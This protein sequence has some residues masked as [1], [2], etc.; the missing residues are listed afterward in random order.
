MGNLILPKSYKSN[1]TLRETQRAIKLLKDTFQV[2]L[3]RALNLDRVTAPV[4]VTKASGINDDLNGIE[5]KVEFDMKNIEGICEVVQSLAKWKRM[6]LYRYGYGAGEGIFTDMNAIRRDDDCDNLHS[7]YVDQWDWEK[8]ICRE[9]RNIDFLKDTVTKIIKALVET[10]DVLNEA[11]PQLTKR[12]NEDVFFI[13]TQELEDMYPDLTGK[14]REN[15]I[16]KKHG[17]V[18]I[19]Q[20]GEKLKSGN[21]HDGRAPDY[22]DWS[23]NGDI[24]VWNDILDCAIEISSMGIRVDEKSLDE[25]LKKAG[26]EERRNFPYHKGI[27]DG[28]LPLTIGGGIGQSRICLQLL[29]KAHIGEVQTSLWPEDMR[30]K[31]KESNI[32]LL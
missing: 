2:K 18:F 32:E 8:V 20:I 13:T 14:Q 10:Q 15:E 3:G 23:L 21:K 12:L 27:L 30:Q 25:Q 1:L 11:F 5:R 19:M 22:D 26:A 7:I 29:E 17:T 6:A 24:L 16:T 9:D 31:C 4:I 28:T